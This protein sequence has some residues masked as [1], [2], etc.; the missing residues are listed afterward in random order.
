MIEDIEGFR[1]NSQTAGINAKIIIP[2]K[3]P[4]SNPIEHR[5]IFNACERPKVRNRAAIKI[6]Q[7]RIVSSVSSPQIQIT[8]WPNRRDTIHGTI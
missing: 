5:S 3:R 4:K 8:I 6:R 1:I 7:T 2:L